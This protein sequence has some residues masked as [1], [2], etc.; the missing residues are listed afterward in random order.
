[1]ASFVVS[2]LRHELMFFYTGRVKPTWEVMWF[3]VLHGVCLV[4]EVVVKR[5]CGAKWRL[6]RVLTVL[7]T[8]TFVM[9]TAS[10][11][12]FPQLL[13]DGVVKKALEEYA[14]AGEFL[15]DVG[16]AVMSWIL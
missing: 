14:A 11:L 13:R 4:I 6:P 7:M 2:G 15:K 12:F 8:V 5:K 9:V 1:M 10:W 3:F 16:R